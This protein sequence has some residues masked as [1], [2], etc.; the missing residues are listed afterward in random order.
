MRSC[1][2]TF[3]EPDRGQFDGY[4]TG[5]YSLWF[6]VPPWAPFVMAD[7]E[8]EEE[9]TQWLGR[10]DSL[11]GARLRIRIQVAEGQA[12]PRI[13]VTATCTGP[14]SYSRV[15]SL[16][17]GGGD[18]VVVRGLGPGRFRV[19]IRKGDGDGAPVM[20]DV[21]SDG[22]GEIPLVLDLR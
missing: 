15:G 14:P 7:T 17:A 11:A 18:E 13:E 19:E 22:S 6:D 16:A 5:T 10:I 3:T 12:V 4:P 21:V 20:R 9:G 1:P 8:L 2:V